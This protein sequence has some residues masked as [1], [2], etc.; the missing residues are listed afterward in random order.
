VRARQ[1]HAIEGPVAFSLAKQQPTEDA[2]WETNAASHADEDP[3][4]DLAPD[5]AAISVSHQQA[6]EAAFHSASQ[7][8]ADFPAE[9]FHSAAEQATEAFHCS[10]QQAI[11]DRFTATHAHFWPTA[12]WWCLSCAAMQVGLIAS[13]LSM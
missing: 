7:Q 13:I 5:D 9:A 1:G 12:N 3:K 6:V 10:A 4:A 11:A 2:D 8:A